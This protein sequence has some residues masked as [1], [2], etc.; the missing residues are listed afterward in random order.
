[1]IWTG[2]FI[3][4]HRVLCNKQ[5]AIYK[6]ESYTLK[7]LAS[8]ISLVHNKKIWTI[9]AITWAESKKKAIKELVFMFMKNVERTTIIVKELPLKPESELKKSKFETRKSTENLSWLLHCFYV[10]NMHAVSETHKWSDCH[11]GLS[12]EIKKTVLRNC[13]QRLE[14]HRDDECALEV[15]RR[16]HSCIDFVD[17]ET[18]YYTACY[19]RFSARKKAEKTGD[20][21]E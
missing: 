11:Y 9:W 6:D 16:L 2:T 12:F 5:C 10:E 13:H 1:M 19:T 7:G 14:E 8:L 3:F 20:W 15:Q 18:C 21:D 4:T 17:A